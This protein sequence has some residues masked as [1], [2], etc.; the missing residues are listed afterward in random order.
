MFSLSGD[1]K[2]YS[3]DHVPRVRYLV[4][5][6]IQ[7]LDVK[8]NLAFAILSATEHHITHYESYSKG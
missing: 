8:Y 7:L 1:G 2:T 3:S 6:C 5:I 4:I